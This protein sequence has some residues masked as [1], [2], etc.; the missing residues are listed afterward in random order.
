MAK[1]DS[2]S[3]MTGVSGSW[4]SMNVLYVNP[5]YSNRLLLQ[6]N[7]ALSRG[8]HCTYRYPQNQTRT[9]KIHLHTSLYQYH[10]IANPAT[11]LLIKQNGFLPLQTHQKALLQKPLQTPHLPPHPPAH[12][13][14]VPLPLTPPLPPPPAPPSHPA[15]DAGTRARG[16]R[17]AFH[18]DETRAGVSWWGE[19]AEGRGTGGAAL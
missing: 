3:R 13:P 18:L 7:T 11:H 6:L 15:P 8:H 17:G 12:T 14:F 9:L 2:S 1:K 4:H 19:R 10:L 5:V 16:P